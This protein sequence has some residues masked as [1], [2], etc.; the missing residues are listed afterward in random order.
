MPATSDLDRSTAFTILLDVDP[1]FGQL[2][3]RV[4]R[5]RVTAFLTDW[6]RSTAKDMYRF[7]VEWVRKNPLA[8]DA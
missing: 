7:A 5:E 2:D 6:S 4:G 1:G 3:V 8:V